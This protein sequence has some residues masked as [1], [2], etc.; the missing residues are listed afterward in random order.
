MSSDNNSDDGDNIV[1]I[2]RRRLSQL[3]FVGEGNFGA[4]FKGN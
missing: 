2:S 3:T 1:Q 4:V